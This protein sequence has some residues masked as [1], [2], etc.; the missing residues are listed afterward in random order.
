MTNPTSEPAPG[1]IC[2]NCGTVIPGTKPDTTPALC[3]DCYEA[4]SQEDRELSEAA[5]KHALT[6][7]EIAPAIRATCN[8]GWLFIG[9]IAPEFPDE[10]RISLAREAHSKHLATTR[11]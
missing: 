6:I 10:S 3:H 11:Q 8:C 5:E 4:L 1:L 2:M 9:S 7:H